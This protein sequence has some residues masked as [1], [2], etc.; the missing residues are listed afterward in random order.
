V[1]SNRYRRSWTP[2]HLHWMGRMIIDPIPEL[3]RRT[4]EG[5]LSRMK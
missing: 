3:I 4:P 5:R 2:E 1:S